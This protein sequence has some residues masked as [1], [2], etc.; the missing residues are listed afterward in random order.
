MSNSSLESKI[1]D[2]ALKLK[3]AGFERSV[4]ADLLD[5]WSVANIIQFVQ[6]KIADLDEEERHAAIDE[7]LRE[8]FGNYEYFN[9]DD[10]INLIRSSVERVMEASDK[11]KHRII[12]F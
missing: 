3:D 12:R 9:E 6:D 11:K 10:L 4:R 8:D 5:K 7:I 1:L 2:A